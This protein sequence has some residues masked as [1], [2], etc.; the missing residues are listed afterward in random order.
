MTKQHEYNRRCRVDGQPRYGHF[1]L[2]GLHENLGHRSARANRSYI[3]QMTRLLW[4]RSN[5][6][7]TPKTFCSPRSPHATCCGTMHLASDNGV[8]VQAYRRLPKRGLARCV[9]VAPVGSFRPVAPARSRRSDRARISH[10][11]RIFITGSTSSVSIF[12]GAPPPARGKFSGDLPSPLVHRSLKRVGGAQSQLGILFSRPSSTFMLQL[13]RCLSDAAQEVSMFVA[14]PHTSAGE[15]L[16][17]ARGRSQ[18]GRP[19]WTSPGVHSDDLI[20]RL[21]STCPPAA[22]RPLGTLYDD[23]NAEPVVGMACEGPAR[24]SRDGEKPVARSNHGELLTGLALRRLPDQL[25]LLLKPQP[26]NCQKKP[27]RET[28]AQFRSRRTSGRSAIS[29]YV[30]GGTR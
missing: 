18:I 26:G 25:P 3:A 5:S 17:R 12:L 19:S 14:W 28:K 8:A 6:H 27:P 23:T 21:A 4:R 22:R 24:D 30:T 15:I 16:R 13:Q 20:R 10:W 11:R 2:Q 1:V 9:R 7:E 29:A